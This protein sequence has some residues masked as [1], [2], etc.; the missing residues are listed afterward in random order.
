MNGRYADRSRP[1][2]CDPLGFALNLLWAIGTAAGFLCLGILGSDH[3]D[4]PLAH[5]PALTNPDEAPA[6]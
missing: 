2:P 3:V 4:G 5:G 6:S 1:R